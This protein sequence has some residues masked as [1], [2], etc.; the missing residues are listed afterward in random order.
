MEIS[1][2]KIGNSRGVRLPKKVI[3]QCQI[4]NTLQLTVE[5]GKIILEPKEES[6]RQ[7]WEEAALLA[8]QEQDEL[9]DLLD[10]FDDEEILEW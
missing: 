5:D 3:D 7:G 8:S 2:I 4:E 9:N 1:L 10:T 6:P